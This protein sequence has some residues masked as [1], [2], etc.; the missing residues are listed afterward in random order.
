MKTVGTLKLEAKGDLEIQMTR[1]FNAPRALVFEAI[2]KPELIRRWLLGPDGWVMEVCEIDLRVGGK[3]RY[4]WR[5]EGGTVMGMGGVY[6][7]IQVSEKIVHTEVFDASWYA[8][9]ALVTTIFTEK[10]GRTIVT[11][12]LRYESIAARDSVIHSPMEGG[13]AQSYNRLEKLLETR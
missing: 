13:V 9:E 1:E 4:V 11:A 7:E 3:Y 12:T 8:G 6:K 2:T 10:E 5:N